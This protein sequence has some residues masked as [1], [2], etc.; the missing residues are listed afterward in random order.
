MKHAH[1]VVFLAAGLQHSGGSGGLKVGVSYWLH[2]PPH[3]PTALGLHN[4]TATI[5]LT[6]TSRCPT[7]AL[8]IRR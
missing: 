6:V 8:G 2:S 4:P 5:K 3:A 7:V 1:E